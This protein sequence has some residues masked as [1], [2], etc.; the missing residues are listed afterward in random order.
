MSW[1]ANIL[2][3]WLLKQSSY[4]K[5]I[6][7]ELSFET[8]K[9]SGNGFNH[10]F[11]VFLKFP[12]TLHSCFCLHLNNLFANLCVCMECSAVEYQG[13]PLECLTTRVIVIFAAFFFF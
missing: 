4:L 5:M 6:F 10:F 2:I 3:T 7:Y 1:F 8:I 9:D 13:L 12:M 11:W